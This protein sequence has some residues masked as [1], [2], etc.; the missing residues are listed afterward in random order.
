MSWRKWKHVLSVYSSRPLLGKWHFKIHRQVIFK[1][2]I[3]FICTCECVGGHMTL[4][5]HRTE[6]IGQ[7]AGI[8]PFLPPHGS[9]ELNSGPQGWWKA[10][11]L[12][13]LSCQCIGKILTLSNIAQSILKSHPLNFISSL[14]FI[15]CQHR[16]LKKVMQ[17]ISHW[18]A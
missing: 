7:P 10:I 17:G 12:P 16:D 8:H 3:K 15:R 13:E 11:L 18:Q 1:C 14:L 9:Q 4:P 6:V 2:Y 5:C